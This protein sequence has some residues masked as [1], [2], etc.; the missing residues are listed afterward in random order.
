MDKGW[1][2]GRANFSYFLLTAQLCWKF[3][4]LATY[5]YFWTTGKKI[6]SKPMTICSV[7]TGAPANTLLNK[8]ILQCILH[9]ASLDLCW[10]RRGKLWKTVLQ[11]VKQQMKI[12]TQI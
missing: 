9:A 10:L 8:G 5:Q 12:L 4:L 11:P 2:C 7:L 1:I 6:L 3:K